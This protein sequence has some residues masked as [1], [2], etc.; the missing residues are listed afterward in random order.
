ME[1]ELGRWCL[2]LLL[3]GKSCSLTSLSSVSAHS[4]F[5]KTTEVVFSAMFLFAYCCL[6]HLI[7]FL[8]LFC[9]TTE[10][11]IIFFNVV[12]FRNWFCKSS[13]SI[14]SGISKRVSFSCWGCSRNNWKQHSAYL[15]R[16][17]CLNVRIAITSLIVE[18]NFYEVITMLTKVKL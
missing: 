5:F 10:T 7:S 14:V 12:W 1:K 2:L 4:S 3:M 6:L 9:Y 8:Y 18:L 15:H 16:W 17:C 11:S 13:S